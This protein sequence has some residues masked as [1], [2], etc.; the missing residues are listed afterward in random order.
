MA[1]KK[2]NGLVI[3]ALLVWGLIFGSAIS[4]ADGSSPVTLYNDNYYGAESNP[5]GNQIG[6][7]ANYTNIVQVPSVV[8]SNAA[9]LVAAVNNATPGTV[10][11]VD[12]SANIDMS[13]SPTLK[14][15]NGVTLASGRGK[16]LPDGSVS[17]GGRLYINKPGLTLIQVEGAN[18]R[19]TGLRL[20]GLD[21]IVGTTTYTPAVTTG[22]R[23]TG[24]YSPEID[25]NEITGWSY[26]GVFASN[27][28]IHHNYFHHN[29]RVGLGYG[30]IV[31]GNNAIT[32]VGVLIEANLFDWNRH[33]IAGSGDVKDRYEARYN[34]MKENNLIT[35][36]DMHHWP[37]CNCGG[38]IIHIHHNTIEVQHN[39][40]NEMGYAM[41][42]ANSPKTALYFYNNWMHNPN[43]EY[44]IRLFRQITDKVHVGM[45]KYGTGTD[46]TYSAMYLYKGEG[47]PF[48]SGGYIFSTLPGA[49]IMTEGRTLTKNGIDN[50]F[51][52][53]QIG[54]KI[55]YD[56]SVGRADQ[57]SV[58]MFK[59]PGLTE[60]SG[61]IV[62][63]Y[64]DGDSEN[65]AGIW[66]TSLTPYTNAS[67]GQQ[68]LTAGNHKVTLEVIGKSSKSNDYKVYFR[69]LRLNEDIGFWMQADKQLIRYGESTTVHSIRD[70]SSAA[71][72]SDN[73][74]IARVSDQGVI[75]GL[76]PGVALITGTIV[77]N[78]I[79]QS[80]IVQITVY[81]ETPPIVNVLAAGNPIGNLLKVEDDKPLILNI[82]ATDPGSGIASLSATF[83]GQPY[84]PAAPLDLRSHLGDH[85]LQVIATDHSGNQTTFNSTIRVS[86]SLPA[87]QQILTQYEAVGEIEKS[88]SKDLNKKLDDA[89]NQLDNGKTKQT[90]KKLE[91]FVKKL[92]EKKHQNEVSPSARAVMIFDAQYLINSW[93]EVYD[94]E[95]SDGEAG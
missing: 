5:T 3:A 11:Y 13:D 38:D 12:N 92:N 2:V 40:T 49:P 54:D 41:D 32:N 20:D 1:T 23:I 85:T 75:T 6:G 37:A 58:Q 78:G 39:N 26:A 68:S 71:F 76:A 21:Y 66:D 19:I 29:Q 82:T 59:G 51:N 91:D 64:F 95:D 43:P 60:D 16:V 15:K 69:M 86:T 46:I 67:I 27:G 81:D 44:G 48:F 36:M 47:T 30:I 52:A 79:P 87:L 50:V 28:H 34:I 24:T 88:L 63:V 8:V 33:N 89:Q 17:P 22:I 25:N 93:V 80:S 90:S 42:A 9:D 84:T 65:P 57:F 73:P 14:L 55:T 74:A 83:D 45:N 56:I 4:Y 7:G 94:D 35:A 18:V 10:I 70:L 61:A 31:S 72:V 53:E 62:K 77:E